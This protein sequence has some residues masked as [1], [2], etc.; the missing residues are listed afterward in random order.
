MFHSSGRS[1]FWDALSDI[2]L[3]LWK[4]F[5]LQW[6]HPIMSLF[7]LLLPCLLVFILSLFRGS[8]EVKLFPSITSYN[9][10]PL[11][12]VELTQRASLPAKISLMYTPLSTVNDR[13]IEEAVRNLEMALAVPFTGESVRKKRTVSLHA[14]FLCSSICAQ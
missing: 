11:T 9:S 3:L 7:E 4:N 12:K 14:N 5:L 8:V 2:R 6:R 13:V 1:S 10:F